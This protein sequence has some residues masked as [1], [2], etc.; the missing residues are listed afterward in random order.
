MFIEFDHLLSLVGETD[1]R[2]GN[3]IIGHKHFDNRTAFGSDRRDR[4]PPIQIH[5][6]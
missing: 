6:K 4:L 5:E 3:K 1:V 2:L